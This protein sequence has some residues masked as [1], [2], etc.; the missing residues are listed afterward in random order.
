VRAS[1]RYR[2]GPVLA[3]DHL[4]LG[5]CTIAAR[6]H[7]PHL[8]PRYVWCRSYQKPPKA[9]VPDIDDTVDVVHGHQQLAQWNAHYDERCFR[10][11]HVYDAATGAPVVVILRPGKTPSGIEVRKL[12]SRLIGR[13]RR[14]WLS[15]RVTIRGD[16][17]CGRGEAI[18]WCENASTDYIFGFAGNVVLD[19]FVEPTAD[20]I[21]VRRVESRAE[22]LRRF[23]DYPAS[24]GTMSG[25]SS[26]GSRP[27]PCTPMTCCA[28]ASIR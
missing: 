8:R 23:A 1:A 5:E 3:A 11:I 10:P 6:D 14:H 28:E 22:V 26:P 16:G 18:T 20:D 4:A 9:V 2:Q 27:A 24:R 12:L 19:W 7:S 15:S 25:G 17:H 13:I 21:R